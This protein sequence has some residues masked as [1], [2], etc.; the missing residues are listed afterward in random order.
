M[1]PATRGSLLPILGQGIVS[2]QVLCA[3]TTTMSSREPDRAK[4]AQQTLDGVCAVLIAS[5]GHC[6]LIYV[7]N[8]AVRD[9]TATQHTA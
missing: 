9:V 6:D 4:S 1:L 5:A 8:S 2:A 3:A 7:M